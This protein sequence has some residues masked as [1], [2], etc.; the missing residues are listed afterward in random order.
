[1]TDDELYRKYLESVFVPHK[2]SFYYVPKLNIILPDNEVLNNFTY[3][4]LY[5]IFVR[6]NRLSGYKSYVYDIEGNPT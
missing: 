2:E 6:M 4:D 1:M 3:Y 5:H